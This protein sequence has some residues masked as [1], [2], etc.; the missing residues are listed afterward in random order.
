MVKKQHESKEYKHL[1]EV[2]DMVRIMM[3]YNRVVHKAPFNEIDEENEIFE[4][5]SMVPPERTHK[6]DIK[7]KNTQLTAHYFRTAAQSGFAESYFDLNLEN[8]E[9]K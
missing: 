6:K 7:N 3:I 8:L 2:L 1:C 4:I 5:E 9:Q